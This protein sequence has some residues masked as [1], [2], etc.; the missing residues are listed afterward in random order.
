MSLPWCPPGYTTSCPPWC[1]QVHHVVSPR[2]TMPWCTFQSNLIPKS[3]DHCSQPIRSLHSM[4]SPTSRQN[5]REI[6]RFHPKFHSHLKSKAVRTAL[7]KIKQVLSTTFTETTESKS[8]AA[9]NAGP[10]GSNS[11]KK[12]FLISI[13]RLFSTKL[14]A[15]NT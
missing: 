13:T 4:N 5:F 9:L 3:C 7:L 14:T 8:Q 1:T 2:Y 12:N 15:D 6:V 10:V 11:Q